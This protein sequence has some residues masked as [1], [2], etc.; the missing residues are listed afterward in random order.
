MLLP[1]FNDQKV[2]SYFVRANSYVIDKHR[3]SFLDGDVDHNW[4]I[5]ERAWSEEFKAS[6]IYDESSKM[7]TQLDFEKSEDMTMFLM[8]WG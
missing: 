3:N 1:I 7:F 8:R 4:R 5:L 6:L 2:N